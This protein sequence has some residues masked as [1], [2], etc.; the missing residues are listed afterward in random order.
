VPRSRQTWAQL[1]VE[2]SAQ[3][4]VRRSALPLA[5]RWALRS[6]FAFDVQPHSWRRTHL[7][8]MF[9]SSR[10]RYRLSLAGRLPKSVRSEAR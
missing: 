4:S 6:L 3:R 9:P 1:S 10:C 8:R 7:L 2:P 5:L